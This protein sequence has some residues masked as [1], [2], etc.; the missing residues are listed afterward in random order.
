MGISRVG[1]TGILKFAEI[2][3]CSGGPEDRG[4]QLMIIIII[5]RVMSQKDFSLTDGA[6]LHTHVHICMHCALNKLRKS[7][8]Q[9]LLIHRRH[10]NIPYLTVSDPTCS[11]W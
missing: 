10:E 3:G 6:V 7:S 9:Q 5:K 8:F 2:C 11:D 4:R 1:P